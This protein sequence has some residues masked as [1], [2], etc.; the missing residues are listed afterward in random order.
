M[1]PVGVEFPQRLVL[2]A[3]FFV[4]EAVVLRQ[5]RKG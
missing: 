4:G 5:L 1:P 2:D 3:E